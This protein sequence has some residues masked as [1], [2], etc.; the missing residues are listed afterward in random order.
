MELYSLAV[1]QARTPALYTRFGTP[2]TVEGRFGQVSLHVY[3]ILRRLKSDNPD[4]QKIARSLVDIMFRNLD[5]A[6]RELGVGDLS[7]SRKMRRLAEQF[8]G[9]IAAY[10]K[11]LDTDGDGDALARALGRN[12]HGDEA[13]GGAQILSGYVRKAAL[14]AENREGTQVMEGIFRFP[15]VEG[16]V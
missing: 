4:E 7:V 16:C 5:S 12:I 6:L 2:D 14:L 9:R 11:A 13:A 3:L 10:E 8:Y 15:D 1:R